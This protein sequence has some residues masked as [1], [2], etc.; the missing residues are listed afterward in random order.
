MTLRILIFAL[1]CT[2]IHAQE[3]PKDTGILCGENCEKHCIE[4]ESAYQTARDNALEAENAVLKR[5]IQGLKA[6]IASWQG[7][8]A[9][10]TAE[11]PDEKQLQAAQQSANKALDAARDALKKACGD[12]WDEGKS[13]CGK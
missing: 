12:K 5:T 8:V 10:I 7:I 4:P 1:A 11:W 3:R 13:T 6:T 9:A 2:A